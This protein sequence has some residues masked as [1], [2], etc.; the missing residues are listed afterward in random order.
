MAA[1]NDL[2]Y[3][4]D[5]GG[6]VLFDANDT[7]ISGDIT[8][9]ISLWDTGSEGNEEP[10]IGPNTV[11]NQLAPNT[12]TAGEGKVQLLNAVNDGFT[13]PTVSSLLKVSISAQ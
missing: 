6:I 2:F 7:P 1:T 10:F 11:T 5:G 12:G 4:P 8:D 13:Y 3:G 9:Q